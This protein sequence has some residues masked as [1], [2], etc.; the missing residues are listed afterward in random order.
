MNE[1]EMLDFVKAMSDPDRLR[2]V[3]ALIQGPRTASQVADALGIPLRKAFNHLAFLEHVGV[4]LTHFAPRIEDETY[5]L[6]SGFLNG[7]ARQQLQGTQPVY[8]P[9]QGAEEDTRRVLAAYLGPDGTIRQI[10][11]SRSQ[12]ARFRIILN[13]LINAFE[14]GK[15]YTEKEVNI[16]LKGFNE[17]VAGLR[18]DLVDAGMLARERDGSKYWRPEKRPE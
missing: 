13:Y 7:L 4:V 15:V 17:D 1:H 8:A 2:I 3:G 12:P 16:I 10:P 14:F 6:D 9:A 5:E 11:N 18:R